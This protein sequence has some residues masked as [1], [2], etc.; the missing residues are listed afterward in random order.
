MATAS[1]VLSRTAWTL[2]GATP[3]FLQSRGRAQVEVVVASAAPSGDVP[4]VS[5]GEDFQRT[6]NIT[7][8]GQNVYARIVGGY[9][10]ADANLVVVS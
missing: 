2:V 3:C 1:T 9:S 7:L 10:P 6:M 5:L 4:A 8:S